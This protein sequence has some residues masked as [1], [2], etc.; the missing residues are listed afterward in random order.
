MNICSTKPIIVANK[1]EYIKTTRGDCTYRQAR[2]TE[3]HSSAC[4]KFLGDLVPLS[5]G[6]MRERERERERETCWTNLRTVALPST[7]IYQLDV[8]SHLCH[9][10]KS[11][12][13]ILWRVSK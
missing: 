3:G 10:N 8:F 11:L 7:E 13:V 6:S 1:L 4:Y 12:S 5:L 9:G 2:L